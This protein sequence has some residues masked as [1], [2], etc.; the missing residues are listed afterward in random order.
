MRTDSGYGGIDRRNRFVVRPVFS[1]GSSARAAIR[2]LSSGRLPGIDLWLQRDPAT[3][4]YGFLDCRGEWA[5]APQYAGGYNFDEQGF[6]VVEASR[7]RWGAI[8]RNNRFVVQPN[9]TS[10]VDAR[11]ALRRITR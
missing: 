9:F 3:G 7:G 4:L 1:D 5:V 6:A 8:D 11:A 2:S 10:S